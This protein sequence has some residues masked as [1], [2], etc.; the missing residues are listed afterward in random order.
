MNAFVSAFSFV[1]SLALL[2]QPV[3]GAG[4]SNVTSGLSG[5][6]TIEPGRVLQKEVRLR[7]DTPYLVK[8]TAADPHHRLKLRVKRFWMDQKK[9]D[10]GW[11]FGK[12]YVSCYLPSQPHGTRPWKIYVS[13]HEDRPV[14][15]H[16]DVTPR[17]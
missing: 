16:I 8:V 11:K 2:V 5:H 14:T 7:Q 10:S 17:R 13:H 12:G 1:L 4:L 3:L 15:V 9:F 6:H